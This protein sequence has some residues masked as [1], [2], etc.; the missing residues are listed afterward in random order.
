MLGRGPVTHIGPALTD[1]LEDQVRPEAMDLGKVDAQHLEHGTTHIE[2]WRVGVGVPMACRGQWTVRRRRRERQAL[3]C[4]FDEP[5]TFGNMLV[6]GIVQGQG[7]A[8]G[9]QVLR[10]VMAFQ[11]LPNGLLTGLTARVAKGGQY[12]RIVLPLDDRAQD[13]HSPSSR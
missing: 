10:T 13:P 4:G 6:V 12:S 3:Q 9:Q 5:V 7:L 8:Q 2:C 1:Q 11:G